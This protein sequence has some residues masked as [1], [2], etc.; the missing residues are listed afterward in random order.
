MNMI[1]ISEKIRDHLIQQNAQ[2][3]HDDF[4]SCRYRGANG[5]MCA[6]GCLIKD[7]HYKLTFEGLSVGSKSVLD[8][9]RKSGL[10][11][12]QFD[13]IYEMLSRWQAYHDDSY[14]DWLGG[15]AEARSPTEM[16]NHIIGV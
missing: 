3:V 11:F 5:T 14:R 16:H 7:E 12:V 8:A 1:Q 15:S 4:H 10:N 2:S 6:V 13:D 9:L